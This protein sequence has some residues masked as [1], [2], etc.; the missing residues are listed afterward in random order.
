M[1]PGVLAKQRAL[2]SKGGNIRPGGKYASP[3]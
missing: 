2:A 1:F 3:N